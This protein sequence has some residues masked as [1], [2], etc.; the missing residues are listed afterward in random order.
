MGKGMFHANHVQVA[1]FELTSYNS[2]H[3]KWVLCCLDY[4]WICAGSAADWRVAGVL[5]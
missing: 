4:A 3:G 2:A 1:Q 5:R